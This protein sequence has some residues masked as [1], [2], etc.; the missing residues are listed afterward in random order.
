MHQ[1]HRSSKIIPEDITCQKDGYVKNK[2]IITDC[3]KYNTFKKVRR[4]KVDKLIVYILL[5]LGF[6]ILIS[7][8]KISLYKIETA[9][10]E[11]QNILTLDMSFSLY[12][13]ILIFI[14]IILFLGAH[15]WLKG[16]KKLKELFFKYISWLINISFSALAI[17][18]IIL[19]PHLK[20]TFI[21]LL[22]AI[23][24][25]I[26]ILKEILELNK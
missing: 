5:L 24:F 23:F 6:I 9:I 26:F 21:F 3:N 13:E 17:Y 22:L 18:L 14:S 8:A 20:E 2:Q 19:T 25:C 7:T 10:I 4:K 12:D 15:L 11:K 1:N 16:I